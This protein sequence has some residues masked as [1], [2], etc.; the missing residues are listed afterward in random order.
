MDANPDLKDQFGDTALMR[1][2]VGD[3]LKVVELLLAREDV[4]PRLKNDNGITALDFVE[5]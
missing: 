3:H 2:A 4:D 1:A 5:S